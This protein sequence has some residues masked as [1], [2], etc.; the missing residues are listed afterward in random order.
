[1]FLEPL[2]ATP[3]DTATEESPGLHNSWFAMARVVYGWTDR[4]E[5]AVDKAWW[6]IQ[7]RRFY[8]HKPK[9]PDETSIGEVAARGERLIHY[10]LLQDD[11][12]E[13]NEMLAGLASRSS[14]R[15]HAFLGEEFLR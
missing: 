11:L 4:R 6:Q 2:S 9:V 10:P 15:G 8:S 1:M 3:I 5:S 13:T 12:R 14:C 7:A